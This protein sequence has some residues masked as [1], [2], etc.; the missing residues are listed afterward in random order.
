MKTIKMTLHEF[1]HYSRI[2]RGFKGTKWID[3]ETGELVEHPG[4]GANVGPCKRIPIEVI[5]SAKDLYMVRNALSNLS[6][7]NALLR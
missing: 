3:D 5:I 2:P 7:Y 1:N 6:S 4:P